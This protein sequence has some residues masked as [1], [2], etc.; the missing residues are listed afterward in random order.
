MRSNTADG[1]GP[2]RRA[3]T[4]RSRST[5]RFR[6]PSA[7]RWCCG[8]A[9]C[10]I[11][12]ARR[13]RP[14]LWPVPASISSSWPPSASRPASTSCSPGGLI[15]EHERG[16]AA[17]R[18]PLARDAIYEDVPWLRRRAA[19]PQAGRSPRGPRQRSGR[20]GRPLGRGARRNPVRSRRWSGRS[21]SCR[22]FTPTAMRRGSAARRSTCGPR[23]SA[24][25]NGSRCSSVTRAWRSS[26]AS[27][28][29]RR[30]RSARSW[31]HGARRAPAARS[32]TPSAAW[33]R[34]TSSKA[35]A[36]GRSRR[37]ASP[38][39]PSPRTASP[40]RPPRSD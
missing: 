30:A 21:R 8:P 10:R 31:R 35:T 22:R 23:G 18:H 13:Q 17:F 40:A 29:R 27:W 14:R 39:T 32:V 26:P 33:P 4:W 34:S 25:P 3:W 12:P 19:A 1:C 16:R 37:G 9:T 15:V 6:R 11:R 24:A 28:P 20:G 38:P 7:T 2:G 5:Y 36:N